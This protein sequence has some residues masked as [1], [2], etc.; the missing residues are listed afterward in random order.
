MNLQPSGT[1]VASN[2]ETEWKVKQDVSQEF[3]FTLYSRSKSQNF[4]AKDRFPQCEVKRKKCSYED[5]HKAG[6]NN[7]PIAGHY[8]V[9]R[10][11][12]LI[13][14]FWPE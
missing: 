14:S 10:R 2:C 13:G 6:K 12:G 3:P 11:L 9:R 7:Y 4:P 8:A 5:Q 1:K